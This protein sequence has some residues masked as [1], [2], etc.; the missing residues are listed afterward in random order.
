[1]DLFA[2]RTLSCCHGDGIVDV[3]SM[4]DQQVTLGYVPYGY[5]VWLF[6]QV[7]FEI[8]ISTQREFN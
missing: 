7:R 4:E 8:L 6:C 2:L 1:M 3:T 5:V